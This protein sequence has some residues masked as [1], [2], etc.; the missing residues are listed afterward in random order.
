MKQ[1][2]VKKD[3]WEQIKESQKDPEF[4]RAAY[5]FIRYHT[6]HRRNAVKGSL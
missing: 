6:S 5:E 4:I 1:K 3:I 2:K